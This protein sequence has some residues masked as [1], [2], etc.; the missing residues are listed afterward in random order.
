[1]SIKRKADIVAEKLKSEIIN[2]TRPLG[3]RLD[4]RGLA[5]RFNV[6]RTPVREA[7]RQLASIGLLNDF[8]RS[9]IEVVRPDAAAI[10]DSFLIVSELEG[11]AARL[12][13]QRMT[14]DQLR[15]A[16]RANDACSNALSVADFNSANMEFHNTIISGSHNKMLQEQLKIARPITFPYRHHLTY[17]PGYTKKSIVEHT[18]II[19]FIEKGDSKAAK[20]AMCDHVN[21]QGEEIISILQA[22]DHA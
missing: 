19:A 11:I 1:M 17:V 7:I 22:L 2:G 12:A 4:E 5:V 10:L 20:A 9:G 3:T 18:E 21:L 8:G 15:K 16:K 6:S 13:A 14:I